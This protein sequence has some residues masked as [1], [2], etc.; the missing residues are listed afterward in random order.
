MAAETSSAVLSLLGK[1]FPGGPSSAVELEQQQ[2]TFLA[3]AVAAVLIALTSVHAAPQSWIGSAAQTLL[4]LLRHPVLQVSTKKALE[5]AL[6]VRNRN[7]PAFSSAAAAAVVVA[8]AVEASVSPAPSGA[9]DPAVASAAAAA[10]PS[11]LA[12]ASSRDSMALRIVLC[13]S[14]HAAESAVCSFFFFFPFFPSR[15]PRSTFVFVFVK[16]WLV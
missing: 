4:P 15:T 13:A 6:Q 12:G 9:F 8:A 7:T 5:A 11:A 16:D 10:T 3:K 1:P 14:L 2:N